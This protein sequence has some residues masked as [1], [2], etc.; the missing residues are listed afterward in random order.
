[1]FYVYHYQNICSLKNLGF[2]LVFSK[3]ELN[4][5]YIV[6]VRVIQKCV[7][8]KKRSCLTYKQ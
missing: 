1:M 5:N 4:K 6:Y 2:Q 7:F 8:Y 3:Y